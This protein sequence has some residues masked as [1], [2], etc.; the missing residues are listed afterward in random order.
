MH[1]L[2]RHRRFVVAAICAFGTGL[3]I[4]V[5]F[6][7]IV[8]FLSAVWRE[9]QNYQDFLEREGRKTPTNP[10]LV[11]LGI[12]EATI[13]T[14]S[15]LP[16]E[17][18]GNRAFELM[19]AHSPPWSRELW[20]ILL[21]R[22]FNAGARVVMFDLVFNPP[23]EGDAIFRDAIDRYRDR[24][25]LGANFD[26]EHGM[27]FVMP[28]TSLIPAPQIQDDRVGYVIFFPDPMDQKVRSTFYTMSDRLLAG[29]PPHPTQE[30]YYSLSARALTKLGVNLPLDFQPHQFRC[31][32]EDAYQPHSL[33]EI[34]D[35]RLWQANYA[36]G[37]FFKDKIV[38]VGAA[39]KVVHDVVT[40]PMAPDTPGPVLHLQVIA[41]TLAGDFLH[42]TSERTDLILVL[43]AGALAWAL[44]AFVRRPLVCLVAIIAITAAY[45]AFARMAYDR[46]GL[47]LLVVP[48]LTGFLTSGLLSLGFEYALERLEKL[49]TRRTLERYVSKNLVKEIL[50]N[51]DSFYS[52]LR[53]V[54]IPATILFS[55]I[56]GF[57]TMTES[58]DP[59]KLVKQLN[60]YLSRMTAAVFENNGTLDK[61]IGDAVMAVWGNVSSRGVAEDAKACARA[62]LAMRRELRVLNQKWAAEGTAAFAIGI[63]IN[64]GDVLGGNIGSQEKADPTV[65]GDA[66]NLASRLEALTRIYPVDILVG[67]RASE[68]IRDE[69]DLRSVALVQVKG[70]TKPVEIFTL[71]GAKKEAGDREFLERLETYEAGFRKFRE[72]DFRQAKILFSQF[73]EFYPDDAL[74]R[75][76]LERALEY[77]KQPPDEAWNAVEVFKKK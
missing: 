23:N 76:Y 32:E 27:K 18:A 39:S 62:A 2:S 22:L 51:P 14:S 70:K 63:G 9:E 66:V 17:V 8:P 30:V 55:D 31:S 43:L 13:D 49:R 46:W 44:I 25:V 67:A 28:N 59:E 58:A 1:W 75:M 11:F 6:F 65:I 4:A 77:E 64:H 60:E 5:H 21:D 20:A 53:G 52:S 34:F 26:A 73:L 29:Q 40:T 36:N 35:P 74:A 7:P 41:A 68:L 42:N 61:F 10:N 3:I 56:V 71:I 57:T 72:R 38:I 48:V 24:V 50:D 45:L 33:Y 16:E 47:L 69:F 54:R 12:D 37:A 15:L 19:T